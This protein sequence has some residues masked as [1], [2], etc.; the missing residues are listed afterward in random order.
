MAEDERGQQGA[1][2]ERTGAGEQV[3]GSDPSDRG[4]GELGG[5]R[6]G[7]GTNSF[8]EQERDASSTG[9]E[10]DRRKGRDSGGTGHPGGNA[11]QDG[12]ALRQE[13]R[14]PGASGSIR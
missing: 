5:H 9:L 6:A 3:D 10:R 14:D 2:S 11:V 1:G 12:G 13:D 7:I 8:V 4:Q